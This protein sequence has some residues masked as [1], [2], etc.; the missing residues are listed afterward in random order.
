[1]RSKTSLFNGA[2]F[3]KNLT[4]FAPAWMLYTLCLIMGMLVLYIS[5]GGESWFA[6][7]MGELL[8]AVM[9][10]V[11]LCYAP[12]VA[13][14]L[15]GDLYNSRM[16]YALHAMPL[17]REGW[18]LTNVLSGLAFSALPTAIMALLSVPL[19]MGTCVVNGWLLA[20]LWFVGTNLEFICFF[21]VAVFSAFCVGNR[22]AMALVYAALN[23]GAC[24]L[25]WIIGH[26]YTPMLYG[27]VAPSRWVEWLT[28]VMHMFHRQYIGADDY[29]ELR[30]LFEGRLDEMTANFWVED[31]YYGL[32]VWAAVGLAF[33][34][35]ALL[36]YRRRRLECA[37]DILAVRALE[38]VFAVC[39]S[40]AAAALAYLVAENCTGY[41]LGT[42]LKYPALAPGLLIGWFAAR[43]CIERSVRVFR[44]KNW[45]GLLG[46]AAVL[47]AS[48]ALTYFDV[49][50]IETYAPEAEAVERVYFGFSDCVELTQ[51][52]DIEQILRLQ[53]LALE[54]RTDVNG[55]GMAI[56]AEDG[57]YHSTYSITMIFELKDGRTVQRE[58][59]IWTDGEE[60]GIVNEY[61]SRWE[62]IPIQRFSDGEWPEADTIGAVQ[63]EGTGQI[64]QLSQEEAASLL[65]AIRA[66]CEERTMTQNS[67][68]HDGGFASVR[69]SGEEYLLRSLWIQFY[70]KERNIPGDILVCADSEN[71]LNW[72]REHDLLVFEVRPES[73]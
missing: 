19:L 50:G 63:I 28:P 18:L 49:L 34:V 56:E 5:E 45:L 43:M 2:V 57:E 35:F 7:H 65:A 4:R 68:F 51:K 47:G 58:Y 27:V 12:T 16:C 21:G 66:D 64:V 11:N 20:P 30:T 22:F 54:D 73:N 1:M 48:L 9:P 14:L 53:Q 69:A 13:M 24:T 31:N 52:E 15:F 32:I 61:M 3:K 41:R 17:R 42:V 26:I 44:L 67:A 60:R 72:L 70:D 37:G 6:F 36:L 38:P 23:G 62:A 25:Q 8:S 29:L 10:V 46:L 59:C 71:T 55:A 39:V 33:L 40:V